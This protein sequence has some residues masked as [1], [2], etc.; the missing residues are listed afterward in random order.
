MVAPS[1]DA[2][3]LVDLAGRR[4]RGKGLQMNVLRIFAKCLISIFIVYG[5]ICGNGFSQDR[6]ADS[7]PGTDELNSLW[8]RPGEDWSLF[9]GP[10][11]NGRS[12]LRGLVVPLAVTW[13]VVSWTI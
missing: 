5:S 10:T 11:G 8:S 13:P 3:W 6:D 7:K 12:E 2:V 9:L 1:I 4:R